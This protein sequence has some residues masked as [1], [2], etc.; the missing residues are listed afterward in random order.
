MDGLLAFRLPVGRRAGN[1]T[2]S[3]LPLLLG[4]G[5]RHYAALRPRERRCMNRTFQTIEPMMCSRFRDGGGRF[6]LY[7]LSNSGNSLEMPSIIHTIPGVKSEKAITRRAEAASPTLRRAKRVNRGSSHDTWLQDGPKGRS[8]RPLTPGL[9]AAG[10]LA[11]P[12]AAP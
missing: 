9:M 3:I 4:G 5:S 6:D 11:G 1:T 10:W 7:S 12:K 8:A 2:P